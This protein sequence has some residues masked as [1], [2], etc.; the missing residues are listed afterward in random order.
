MQ[1][2]IDP[3][4][5]FEQEPVFFR[6]H[7]WDSL[8]PEDLEPL[9]KPLRLVLNLREIHT[10]YRKHQ[11][12]SADAPVHGSPHAWTIDALT[13]KE[14]P[15]SPLDVPLL[16]EPIRRTPEILTAFAVNSLCGASALVYG[17]EYLFTVPQ[18]VRSSLEAS[19]AAGW[20]LSTEVRDPLQWA[21]RG[22]LERHQD[23]AN[24]V[25]AAP[26]NDRKAMLRTNRDALRDEILRN[27]EDAVLKDGYFESIA[28]ETYP[29]PHER[30]SYIDR[31]WNHG[32]N[33]KR[34][35]SQLSQWT[36]GNA[37]SSEMF[38]KDDMYFV[39]PEMLKWML[40]V[41]IQAYLFALEHVVKYFGWPLDGYDAAF[42]A[43]ADQFP[44]SFTPAVSE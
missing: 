35:Y 9:R 14:G 8:S 33:W 4:R 16:V 41:G 27:F 32:K 19:A 1:S 7:P 37:G 18:L 43:S 36:D 28:G 30:F 44:E 10:E 34:T 3:D 31:A 17:G 40:A 24:S 12:S 11:Q 23:L 5:P 13:E 26:D 21:A 22:F 2:E 38:S 20:L 25:A 6:S 15:E 39:S 29:A 42:R